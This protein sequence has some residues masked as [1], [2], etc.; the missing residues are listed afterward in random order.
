MSIY[1]IICRTR[2]R[3]C[4]DMFVRYQKQ[5]DDSYPSLRCLG[6]LTEAWTTNDS[7]HPLQSSSQDYHNTPYLPHRC[8]PSTIERLSGR[9]TS[10]HKLYTARGVTSTTLYTRQDAPISVT[11]IP[12]AHLAHEHKIFTDYMRSRYTIAPEPR[13]LRALRPRISEI[14]SISHTLT[15]TT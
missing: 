6:T 11:I 4:G 7:F 14:R 9:F 12:T 8:I 1:G 2:R 3:F 13:N 15:T 5:I 10:L